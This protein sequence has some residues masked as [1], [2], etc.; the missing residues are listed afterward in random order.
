M[1]QVLSGVKALLAGAAPLALSTLHPPPHPQAGF[2]R[3]AAPAP[4]SPV[5][6]TPVFQ[7]P[8]SPLSTRHTDS[9]N[10]HLCGDTPTHPPPHD[11]KTSSMKLFL[12]SLGPPGAGGPAACQHYSRANAPCTFHNH[13]ESFS[14]PPIP[15]ERL[16][17]GVQGS[18]PG[19]PPA[20]LLSPQ[21]RSNTVSL[22]AP[23]ADAPLFLKDVFSLRS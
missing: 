22:T 23:A 12:L 10:P 4:P 9:H 8:Q 20:C 11:S 19:T 1:H 14:T 7:P 3:S 5:T 21:E 15:P 13:W 18:D 16:R 17:V 2:P 6:L